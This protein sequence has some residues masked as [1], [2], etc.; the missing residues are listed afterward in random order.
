MKKETDGI[1]ML[2]CLILM[3]ICFVQGMQIRDCQREISNLET[4]ITNLEEANAYW[5]GVTV[6]NQESILGLLKTQVD[7]LG[8]IDTLIDNQNT[9]LDV[10]VARSH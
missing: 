9:I 10:L 6:D 2:L 7:I 8:Y 3:A 1:I 4:R 5:S